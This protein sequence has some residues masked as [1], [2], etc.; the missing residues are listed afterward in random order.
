MSKLMSERADHGDGEIA[1]R[2]ANFVHMGRALIYGELGDLLMR[3]VRHFGE[4][5]PTTLSVAL[6]CFKNVKWLVVAMFAEV[7]N[8]G[9]PAVILVNR[10]ETTATNNPDQQQ[11]LRRMRSPVT[12]EQLVMFGLNIDA[13]SFDVGDSVLY[14]YNGPARVMP[15]FT[16]V[17]LPRLRELAQSRRTATGR[18]QDSMLRSQ[19]AV[20][21]STDAYQMWN[22]IDGTATADLGHVPPAQLCRALAAAMKLEVY[23]SGVLHLSAI[24]QDA[25]IRNPMGIM[26]MYVLEP[27]SQGSME[28]PNPAAESDFAT[29][30]CP[31]S[32]VI[33][34]ARR[35]VLVI[36]LRPMEM[37]LR[38]KFFANVFAALDMWQL[39]VYGV[40]TSAAGITV[41]LH[42]EVPLV[43]GGM[44]E[45]YEITDNNLYK[46][47]ED[48]RCHGSVN[49]GVDMAIMSVINRQKPESAVLAGDVVSALENSN[50]N[51]T[52]ISHGR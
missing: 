24:K 52:M 44:K 3:L 48:L 34:T 19:L 43:S 12:L 11:L 36:E 46:A 17:Q 39:P 35:N 30:T 28:L 10:L 6:L 14:G 31:G 37:H 29:F 32:P 18:H 27:G 15:A 9:L 23:G 40:A 50:I 7:K 38:H 51:I 49:F 26:P 47:V 21:I 16:A 41:S 20:G 2:H 22:P 4:L 1:A 25:R 33:L 8:G 42:S 45:G 13:G 5:K